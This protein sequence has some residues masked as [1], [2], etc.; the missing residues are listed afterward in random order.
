MKVT[1]ILATFGVYANLFNALLLLL[2]VVKLDN[3]LPLI[4]A[5]LFLVLAS[6]FREAARTS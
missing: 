6:I 4:P 5:T 1:R 3:P 2:Y